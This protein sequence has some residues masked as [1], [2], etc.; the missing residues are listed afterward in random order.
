MFRDRYT[1]AIILACLLPL[2]RS[3]AAEKRWLRATSEHFELYTTEDKAKARAALVQFEAARTS[4]FT[5]FELI[6]LP[7]AGQNRRLSV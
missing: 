5:R 3:L 7:G 4:F 1:L 6:I 2:C